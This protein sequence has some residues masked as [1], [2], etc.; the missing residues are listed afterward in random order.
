MEAADTG[1]AWCEIDKRIVVKM[2]VRIWQETV[3]FVIM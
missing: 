1:G 3:G 2:N